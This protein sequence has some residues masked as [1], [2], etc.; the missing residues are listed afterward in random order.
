MPSLVYESPVDGITGFLGVFRRPMVFR[1]NLIDAA[2]GTQFLVDPDKRQGGITALQL[3]RKFLS[4]PQQL[5]ITD[6]AQDTTRLLWQAAGGD[7]VFLQCLDW[8]RIL[9][10]ASHNLLL[11]RKRKRLNSFLQFLTPVSKVVDSMVHR[12]PVGPYRLCPASGVKEA[13]SLDAILEAMTRFSKQYSLHPSLNEMQ[14]RWLLDYA[15]LSEKRGSL[16]RAVARD[17]RGQP[18]GWG[19]YYIQPGDTCKV[20]QVGGPEH[21]LV[22]VLTHIYNHAWRE[23]GTAVSGR[24]QPWLLGP[25]P[26]RNCY[27]RCLSLGV[28]AHSKNKDILHA[29]HAGDAFLSRLE[30][31]WWMAFGERWR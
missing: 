7:A 17:S 14:L 23:G 3:L 28:L 26:R 31:E 24:L 30:G 22:K 12:L 18:A 19:L 9:R 21:Y 1:G 16:H 11:L 15:T 2:I 10:P 20:L 13:A 8:F 27:A 29:I 5:S 6:G 4:G 25:L